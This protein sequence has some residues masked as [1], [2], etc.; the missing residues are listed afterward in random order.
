MS[1]PAP[2]ILLVEDNP[3][4]A[5]LVMIAHRL[6]KSAYTIQVVRDGVAALDFLLGGGTGSEGAQ[7][8][9]PRLVLLDLHLPRLN[10]FEVLERLRADERTRLLPV[11]I[12]SSSEQESDV[13]KSHRLGANGYLRKPSN[14][15]TLREIL[16]Q[17]ERDWL[18]ADHSESDR[19]GFTLVELL[20]VVAIIAILP[21]LLLPAL[22]RAKANLLDNALKFSARAN[23]P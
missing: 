20:V 7:L 18:K 21:A 12:F 6:N 4:D 14:F 11:I 16:T 2:D 5:D 22:G 10:G 15:Q 9:L 1:L 23:P 3:T 8:P 13:G 17:I 19:S